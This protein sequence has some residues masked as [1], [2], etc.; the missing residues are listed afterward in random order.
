MKITVLLLGLAAATAAACQSAP[1]LSNRDALTAVKLE[2]QVDGEGALAEIEYHIAPADVPPAVRAAMDALHPGGPYTDAE[3][4][5]Q[6]GELYYELNRLVGGLEVEAMFTPEGELHSEELE[7]PA[8]KAPAA[9]RDAVAARHPAGQVTKVEEIR[10]GRRELVQY[11]VKLKEGGR[12][13]KAMFSPAGEHIATYREIVA[14]VEVPVA[15]G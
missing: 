10:D 3:R 14:E 11:H 1:A 5:V 7:I 12:A 4:E 13:Y 15:G 8:A 6:G 2:L 9:V